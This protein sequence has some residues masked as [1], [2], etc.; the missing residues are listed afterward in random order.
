MVKVSACVLLLDNCSFNISMDV[1]VIKNQ[2]HKAEM[3]GF[4]F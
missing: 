3:E 1:D 4:N 2:V